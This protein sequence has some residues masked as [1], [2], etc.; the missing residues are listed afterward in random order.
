MAYDARRA[1]I[2]VGVLAGLSASLGSTAQAQGRRLR[3]SD[4]VVAGV[5]PDMDSATVRQVLGNPDSIA[6]G[7]DPSQSA[8]KLCWYYRDLQVVLWGAQVEGIWLRSSRYATA[9]GLRLGDSLGK[10]RH[11]Y[12]RNTWYSVRPKGLSWE[13]RPRGTGRM[14]YITYTDQRTEWI[15]LGYNGD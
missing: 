11:L 9:R 6:E 4:F 10:A 5:A 1:V 8:P 7:D 12:G 13:E 3:D 15:W 14:V 2:A